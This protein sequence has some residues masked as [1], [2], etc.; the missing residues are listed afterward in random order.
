MTDPRLDNTLDFVQ[1]FIRPITV[2]YEKTIE[3]Q[4]AIVG[5][6][7]MHGVLSPIFIRVDSR[8]SWINVTVTRPGGQVDLQLTQKAQRQA[9]EYLGTK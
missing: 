9:T 5:K 6:E 1:G 2:V 3:E 4:R 8:N 7:G